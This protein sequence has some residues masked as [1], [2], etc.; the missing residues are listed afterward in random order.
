MDIKQFERH[1][2]DCF[3]HQMHAKQGHELMVQLFD[4]HYLQQHP[5]KRSQSDV[6]AN[7]QN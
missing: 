6:T 5:P 2:F 7:T 1:Q 3:L 4:T